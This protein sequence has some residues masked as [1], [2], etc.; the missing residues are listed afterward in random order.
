MR[1]PLYLIILAFLAGCS[2]T[3]PAPVIDRLPTSKPNATSASSISKKPNRP[4]YKTG[5]WR[6]DT[7]VVKKGDT[8]FS[9]WS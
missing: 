7:Y 9:I 5:D 6:P 2:S 1:N 3:P 4:T 8:L